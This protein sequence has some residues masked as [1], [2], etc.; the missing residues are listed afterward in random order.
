MKQKKTTLKQNMLEQKGKR[1]TPH[2]FHITYNWYHGNKRYC[3]RLIILMHHHIII[4]GTIHEIME[5]R[6]MPT[7]YMLV[8]E[9]VY[10]L[11]CGIRT[12]ANNNQ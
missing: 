8:V 11:I 12:T 3:I 7:P 5:H 1:T 10:I 6:I 4:L 2:L 9:G